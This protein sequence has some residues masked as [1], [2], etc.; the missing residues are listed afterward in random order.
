MSKKAV[1]SV[2][3]ATV[4]TS[5]NSAREIDKLAI[6]SSVDIQKWLDSLTYETRLELCDRNLVQSQVLF[7]QEVIVT[8]EKGEWSHVV[9]TEQTSSKD[10]RGYPGWIPSHQL[11]KSDEQVELTQFAIVTRAFTDLYSAQNQKKFELTFQTTL[12]VL[13]EYD[14]VVEVWTPH[15][16]GYLNRQDIMLSSTN[17]SRVKGNGDDIVKAGELFL[18]LPYL[19]GGMSS[20][21]FDCSGFSYTM[22]KANGYLIPRDA[23]DQATKGEN[24]PFDQLKRG[25]LVFFANDEG[26]G[27]V[28]HVG[29]YYGEGKMIHS[30]KT[31]KDIEI[32]S[33][34]GTYYEKELCVARRYWQETEA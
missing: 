7:G 25:D 31:G 4:W 12:P 29:I 16:K 28:R 6:S 17:P 1:I 11:V 20:Y 32:L 14:E 8:E 13:K 9:I 2:P 33:L 22:C 5:F 15:G 27:N 26:K 19:W 18:G 10:N 30:P 21:G 3:V 23:H 24:V 34:E